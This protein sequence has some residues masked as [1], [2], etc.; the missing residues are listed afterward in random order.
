MNRWN[1]PNWLELEV[2]ARDQQCVYCRVS[3]EPAGRTR[4]SRPSWEHIVNDIRIINRENIA[5]CCTSCNSSKGRKEL[6]VWLESPY[7]QKRGI[8]LETIAEV[9]KRALI[10]PPT[11]DVRPEPDTVLAKGIV[12]IR[13]D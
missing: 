3:F 10:K 4:G 5:R 11:V 8:T 1:I 13:V 9:A 7:C 2:L 6:A 12:V